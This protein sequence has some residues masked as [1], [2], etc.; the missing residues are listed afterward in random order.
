MDGKSLKAGA[1]A[2]VTKV[3]NPILLARSVMEKSEHVMLT[4]KG[5]EIFARLQ[6]IKLVEPSYSY[7]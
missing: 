3:K 4:G 1:V 6:N 7:V 5:E 2:G